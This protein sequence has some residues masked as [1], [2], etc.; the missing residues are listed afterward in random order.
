MFPL[1]GPESSDKPILT[2]WAHQMHKSWFLN[3]ALIKYSNGF[4]KN[5]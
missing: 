1:R 5:D 4:L 3:T 2:R